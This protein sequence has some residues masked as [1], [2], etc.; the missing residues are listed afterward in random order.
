MSLCV[1]NN[2]L[3]KVRRTPETKRETKRVTSTKKR[4]KVLKHGLSVVW[5]VTLRLLSLKQRLGP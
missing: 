4:L 1:I 5:L 3:N 2:G